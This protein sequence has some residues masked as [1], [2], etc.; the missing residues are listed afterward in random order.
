[1]TGP[2]DREEYRQIVEEAPL[3]MFESTPE[4]KLL[5]AN[6][7]LARLFGFATPD[8]MVDFYDDLGTQLYRDPEDRRRFIALIDSDD[9][10]NAYEF[11][12]STRYSET[13]WVAVTGHK[14]HEHSDGSYRIRG[15]VVDRTAKHI[16]ETA[17]IETQELHRQTVENSPNAIFS[18][19]LDCRITHLNSAARQLFAVGEDALGKDLGCIGLTARDGS[20][21]HEIVRSCRDG[22]SYRNLELRSQDIDG[23]THFL[24][25][26][27]YPIYDH[28]GVP[29]GCVVANTDITIQVASED[30]VNKELRE[31][32]VL[33]QEVHHR[34]KNNLQMVSSLLNLQSNYLEN[35][36][37]RERFRESTE[38]IRAIARVHEQLYLSD[39]LDRINMSRYLKAMFSDYRI[40]YPSIATRITFSFDVADVSMGLSQALPTALLINELVNN[41]LKHAFST[42]DSG[43]VS[44]SLQLDHD[45]YVLDV[46][47]TGR[48][49]PD[50]LDLAQSRSL[51]L[52]I[53][54]AL[55]LQL[56]G[57]IAVETDA[58]T[59]WTVRFP[60]V[61]V[62]REDAD[63]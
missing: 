54:R 11:P 58:G 29:A 47:D 46:S 31:K 60:V 39:H 4:G 45:H 50:D 28:D 40:H 38:R 22:I 56:G 44:V 51:G 33:L 1:M 49:M 36:R 43:S 35:E 48:G 2:S 5:W 59:T 24:L 21:L 23:N 52:Q 63:N 34:V 32:R 27:A 18:L 8:E 16:L 20:S 37:D 61:P 30:R 7:S 26:R 3:G 13:V 41:A 53:V 19:D 15:Y 42:E 10:V 17:L 9:I 55:S 6:I 25:S 14:V 57:T 12:A 62:E